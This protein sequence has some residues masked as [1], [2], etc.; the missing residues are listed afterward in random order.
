MLTLY[1]APGSSSMVPHIALREIGVDFVAKP[2]SLAARRTSPRPVW[3]SIPQG[4]VSTLFI[5]VIGH[6]QRHSVAP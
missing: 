1:F 3:R 2:L 4:K 6:H 5:V